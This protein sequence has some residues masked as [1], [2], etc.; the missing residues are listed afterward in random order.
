M[1]LMNQSLTVSVDSSE[2]LFCV[3]ISRFLLFPSCTFRHLI[4]VDYVCR[5]DDQV[6]LLLIVIHLQAVFNH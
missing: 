6:G 1:Q 3:S 5:S 4:L 2:I